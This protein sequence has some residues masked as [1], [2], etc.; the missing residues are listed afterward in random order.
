MDKITTGVIIVAGGTGRRMGGTMPKQF[1]FVG[2]EP[3]LV[4][5]I[6]TFAKALPEAK[7]VV[8]LSASMTDFWKNLAAR[9]PV[10]RHKVVTGGT[11]R[12]HSVRNGIEA[13]S[14]GVDLI[15]VHDGVRPFA[16]VELIRRAVECAAANGSAIPAVA[17]VDSLR[18]ISSDGTSAPADRSMFRTVQTP[19]IFGADILRAAYDT[20]YKSVFTDDAS[21][22]EAAGFTVTLCDGERQNIKI[23]T[24]EDMLFAEAIVARQ[25]GAT[26]LKE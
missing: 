10:A 20:E 4:R 23:T 19:Q 24:P 11:E 8:V 6:N 3:I 2:G 9:F 16:S 15:A 21:V 1:A 12:F 26:D 22:V 5:T 17:P 18:A 13:L 7:I 25:S 14:E